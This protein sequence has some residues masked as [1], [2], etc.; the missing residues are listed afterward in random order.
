MKIFIP[1]EGKN[2]DIELYLNDILE[3]HKQ[4]TPYW[5][6]LL[7]REKID[8]LISSKSLEET[9]FNLSKLEVDQN[10]L[11]TNWLLFKPVDLTNLKCSFSSG[12]TG[13]QKYCFWSSEYIEKQAIYLSHYISREIKVNHAIIQGP[14]S[15]YKDVNELTINMLGGLPY[16]IGLRVEGLK[17]VIE[18]AMAK[19]PEELIKVIKEYFKPE[20]DKTKYILERDPEVNFM[21]SAFMMLSFFEEFFGDKKNINAVM[22]SGLG[23]SPENHRLLQQKFKTVIPSYGYFAFGDALGKYINGNLD[24]HPAFPYAIFTVVKENGEIAKHGEGGN[25]LFIIARPDLFLVLKENNEYAIRANPKDE[26]PWD[27]IR[28]PCRKLSLLNS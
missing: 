11:R 17:P 25:P 9:L 1:Y 3:F 13:P 16:F 2:I 10:S 20:L 27:G 15:V 12:T 21:R 5:Q 19:G 23:Y 6:K 28:N 26:I 24:Y 8:D 18:R 4:K 14:S 22:V 7:A